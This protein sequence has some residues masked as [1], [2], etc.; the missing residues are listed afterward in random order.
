MSDVR[1]TTLILVGHYAG[2]T[3]KIRNLQFVEGKAEFNANP[4]DAHGLITY[5]GRCYQAY[6]EGSQE[7]KDALA[8]EQEAQNGER[9]IQEDGER[10]EE[11]PVSGD[12][13]P[14]WEGSP[15]EEADAVIPDVEPEAGPDGRFPS[16]DRQ[17]DS[18]SPEETAEHVGLS[19]QPVA[20]PQIDAR[21]EASVRKLNPDNDDHWTTLGLPKISAVYDAH[22]NNEDI[23]S[24]KAI[25]RAVGEWN[26]EDSAVYHTA[27]ELQE[28]EDTHAE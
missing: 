20:R 24:R 11:E 25:E 22:P 14:S 7:L 4:A 28:S 8:R 1:K 9:Q 18:G 6:P 23:I 21:I 26:R 27:I 12:L 16:W 10:S 17:P 2:R 3:I 15:E 5:Y 19:E 13:Q